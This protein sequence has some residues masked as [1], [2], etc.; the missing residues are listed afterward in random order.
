[1]LDQVLD[2]GNLQKLPFPSTVAVYDANTRSVRRVDMLNFTLYLASTARICEARAIFI[3]YNIFRVS[4]EVR[5][6]CV[7]HCH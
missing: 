1:M 3:L 4:V 2:D 5:P 6:D 7:N